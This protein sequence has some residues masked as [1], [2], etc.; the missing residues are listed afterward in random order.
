MNSMLFCKISVILIT[1]DLILNSVLGD[2][3]ERKLVNDLFRDYDSTVRPSVH[4]ND[5][6]NVTF[7]LSLAQ[8][9]D[10]VHLFLSNI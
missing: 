1:N 9:I 2:K 5:V 10:V 4:H 6:L 3:W 7:G 8:I